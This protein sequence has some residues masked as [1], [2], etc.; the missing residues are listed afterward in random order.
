MP[1]YTYECPN[2]HHTRIIQH[3]RD[4]RPEF[5]TCE[6]C[7]KRAERIFLRT[8]QTQKE[9]TEY[10][11]LVGDGKPKHVR[12]ARQERQIE[13][14]FQVAHVTDADMKDMRDNLKSDYAKRY[15]TDKQEPMRDTVN[16]VLREQAEWG[17]EYRKE[18][19]DRVRK[20][21]AIDHEFERELARGMVND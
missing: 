5:L 7:G 12:D 9:F 17:T 4:P 3:M 20:E 10:V 14:E 11:T 13:K 18:Q 8:V 21:Q 1:T 16:A 2:E 19:E 15:L 6:T